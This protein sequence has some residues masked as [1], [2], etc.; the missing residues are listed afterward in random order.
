ME[1]AIL[2]RHDDSV[3]GHCTGSS[4][5]LCPRAAAGGPVYC[6]GLCLRVGAS[7]T[8]TPAR[9]GRSWTWQVGETATSCPVWAFHHGDLAA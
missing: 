8:G 3:V 5:G 2:A 1:I 7:S 9:G 6:A 4:D